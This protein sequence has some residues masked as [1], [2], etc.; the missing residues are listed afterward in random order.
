MPFN[1]KEFWFYLQIPASP[2]NLVSLFFLYVIMNAKEIEQLPLIINEVNRLTGLPTDLQ[3][4]LASACRKP[5]II[6]VQEYAVAADLYK[7][8]TVNSTP[9]HFL[10]PENNSVSKNL[11]RM[12]LVHFSLAN[13][14]SPLYA[15]VDLKNFILQDNGLKKYFINR[16]DLSLFIVYLESVQKSSWVHYAA[17]SEGEHAE[18][19]I[20]NDSL[21]FCKADLNTLL[22]LISKIKN[23]YPDRSSFRL[24]AGSILLNLKNDQ[25]LRLAILN[26]IDN[27]F[28]KPEWKEMW[29]YFLR[30]AINNEPGLFKQQ[31]EL[32]STAY[33]HHPLTE[34][35]YALAIACPDD[36]F[37]LSFFFDR[38]KAKRDEKLIKAADYLQSVLARNRVDAETT[39]Y[40]S[41]LST[42]SRDK[43]ELVY[44]SDILINNLEQHC[45]EDWFRITI[46]NIMP[47]P[48]Q[49]LIENFNHLLTTL[50][51]KDT[52]LVYYLLKLRFAVNGGN[53]FLDDPWHEL[54]DADP[55]LFE[56]NLVDWFLTGNRNIHLAMHHLSN[57]APVNSDKFKL[58]Q[59]R[60]A[61]LNTTD[62]YYIACK[63]TGYIYDKYILRSLLFSLTA[64]VK[65]NELVLLE[66]LFN[67]FTEYVIHNYRST[68]DEV[69]KII[70]VNNLPSHVIAFYQRIVD[71]FEE[72][73]KGLD[74]VPLLIELRPD[75][76]LAQH[77][78]F[79]TSQQVSE[80]LKESQKGGTARFFKNVTINSHRWAIRRPGETVHSPQT[81][82]HVRSEMEF[83][84]GEI[85]N[86]VSSERFRKV[87]QQLEKHEI[88]IG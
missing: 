71:Y 11:F 46:R 40:I 1:W 27:F 9:G 32:L 75:P 5:E 48:Y 13:Q 36:E 82:G 47:A 56:E 59:V 8:L 3:D 63:I 74:Q 43:Q 79:Y 21:P 24:L 55:A 62:K 84:A 60:L 2:N 51:E 44:M 81:L 76:I 57:D 42:V 22:S 52:Q 31:F 45:Q 41:S 78:N 34:R 30:G 85:L 14:V 28:E 69:K 68:L 33:T 80:Q 67:I 29:P 86:P 61:E 73:F 49:E 6:V 16:H 35:L 7:L 88:N 20:L 25:S 18:I 58:S 17:C 10:K 38:I 66:E 72:Y 39:A 12:L 65:E 15:I 50:I 53:N 70:A 19:G 64:A 54:P 83:P 4:R 26:S 77:I 37:S 23:K 87:Y